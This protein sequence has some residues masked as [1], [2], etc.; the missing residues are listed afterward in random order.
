MGNGRDGAWW[1]VVGTV[2]TFALAGVIQAGDSGDEAQELVAYVVL[3]LG[4]REFDRLNERLF[5]G[6]ALEVGIVHRPAFRPSLR[7]SHE[8]AGGK[9]ERRRY[10]QPGRQLAAPEDP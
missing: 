5:P 2:M 7:H 9:E 10:R 1:I 8:V 3:V 6:Q 4:V